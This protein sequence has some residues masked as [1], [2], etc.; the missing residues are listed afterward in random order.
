MLIAQVNDVVTR[1]TSF[2]LKLHSQRVA[3]DASVLEMLTN[4]E[5]LS[6]LID[7]GIDV[8]EKHDPPAVAAIRD[9]FNVFKDNF[10]QFHA[11]VLKREAMASKN[12]ED[13]SMFPS[14]FEI[15]LTDTKDD[16][17]EDFD[18]AVRFSLGPGARKSA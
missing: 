3:S 2:P 1:E 10:T 13:Y 9:S 14:P 7:N 11:H 8:I 4:F 16:C 6:E 17:R 18:R 15:V 12:F 5:T